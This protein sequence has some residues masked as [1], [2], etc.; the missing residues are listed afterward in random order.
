M[1]ET[2]AEIEDFKIAWKII[3]KVISADD[4]AI[5]AKIKEELQDM[6]QRLV[7]YGRKYA[8]KSISTNHKWWEYLKR[9]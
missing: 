6:V 7:E 5:I 8:W 4:T 3:I 1:K 2:L 9:D